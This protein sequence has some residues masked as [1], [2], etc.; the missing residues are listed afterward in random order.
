MRGLADSSSASSACFRRLGQRR[1]IERGV[2]RE[3]PRDVLHALEE[4]GE[5]PENLP[6]CA[7]LQR[8][9]NSPRAKR[10]GIGGVRG[11]AAHDLDG[12]PRCSRA[13]PD[14]ILSERDG[15]VDV[16]IRA[17]PVEGASRFD[18]Q[19]THADLAI[20]PG[21][22]REVHQDPNDAVHLPAKAERIARSGRAFAG[23]GQAGDGVELVSQRHGRPRDRCRTELLRATVQHPFR[24][25]SAGSD[26][27]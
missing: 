2:R 5:R 21:Q 1:P 10:S 9:G 22:L 20:D 26:G 23:A 11:C 8:G 3:L 6:S 27:R 19:S 18:Q 24:P 13:I 7:C 17:E 12:N 15:G 4:H 16:P 14:P 25:R